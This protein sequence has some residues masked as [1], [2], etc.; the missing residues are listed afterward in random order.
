MEEQQKVSKKEMEI[1]DNEDFQQ[2]N[3][4]NENTNIWEDS[5]SI[6]SK[7]SMNQ[8]KTDINDKDEDIQKRKKRI[9]MFEKEINSYAFEKYDSKSILLEYWKKKRKE[10]RILSHL[11]RIYLCPPPGSAASEII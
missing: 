9:E 11:A 5:S 7:N 8:I 4:K 10:F 6:N 2:K 3:F 1:E